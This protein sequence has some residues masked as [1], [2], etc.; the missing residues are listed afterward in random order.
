MRAAP[1]ESGRLGG[2]ITA[3]LTLAGWSSVPLFIEHFTTSIDAWT[4]NG[5]RYGFSALLWAPLLMVGLVRQ[6]LPRGLFIAA[7]I[8]AAINSVGQVCFTWAYYKIDPALVTFGL[9]THI[10]FV[11][12]GA[13]I[14]FPAERPVIGSPRFLVGL[15][16]V[17][18]GTF[19]TV[20]L[21]E[22]LPTGASLLG[23]LLALASGALFAAYALAVRRCMAGIHPMVAFAAI[24]QYTAAAML[25]LMFTFGANAGA[26]AL[27]L[28]AEQLALLLLSA[29]IGIALGHVLYYISIEKLGVA[30][31]AGVVQ[32]QPVCVGIA[33]FFL[34]GE[35][36]SSSQWSSGLVA[37]T[38]A[39][40][41]LWAQ[42]V[43]QRRRRIA[44]DA[45]LRDLP[46]DHVAAAAGSSQSA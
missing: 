24:S 20:I 17:V 40:L 25:A 23:V 27:V 15:V 36:L 8:P 1:A 30:V 11:T 34:F 29:V 12:I 39:G 22:G 46:P 42:H 21:G 7:L 6:R 2:V 35:A 28:S 18:G 19:G 44:P 32:L 14:M 5:W 43:L 33:S 26:G 13:A 16:M 31:S 37:V 41:M 38:G 10:V 3:L 45:E 4:S 9:R